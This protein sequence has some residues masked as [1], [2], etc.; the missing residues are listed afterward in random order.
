MRSYLDTFAPGIF[1][2]LWSTGF[3]G[4][5]L[6]APYIEPFVFLSI[7]FLLV[8][9]LLFALILA[10]RASWPKTGTEVLHCLVAGALIHGIYLGGIF[11]AIDNG[12]PAGIAALVLGLQPLLTALLAG[13]LLGEKVAARHWAGLAV[14]ACGLL[15][16]VGPRL[17]VDASGLTP[18]NALVCLL[19]VAG[20]SVGTVY[21]KRFAG[22]IDLLSGTLIQYAGALLIVVPLALGES[23]TIVWSGQMIF[24]MGWLVLVLSIGAILLL[25]VLIRRGSAARVASLFYLVPV[26]A[27]IESYFLF[28]E[29][30]TVVQIAGSALVVGALLMIRE[31]R[32]G[33]RRTPA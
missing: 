11:Y 13:P 9:P 29:T 4:S 17:G 19:A 18:V 31:R 23:W 12:M 8:L 10:T 2:L 7:R 16:V 33:T 24:A 20:M 30:L 3:I 6:G 5:K 21:Q 25:M 22:G 26:A 15:L 14:G 32:I 27:A 1:V 28:G